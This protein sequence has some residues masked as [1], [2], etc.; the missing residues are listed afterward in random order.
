MLNKIR[1]PRGE[2]RPRG[3]TRR[4]AA[5]Y[6]NEAVG[7]LGEL[8]LTVPSEAL[9]QVTRRPEVMGCPDI[10]ELLTL[11]FESNDRRVRLRGPGQP[12]PRK[13]FL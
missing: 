10:R 6:V 11:I 13:H 2:P 4:T 5:Y 9:S 8:L 12:S 7:S 1:P 3:A